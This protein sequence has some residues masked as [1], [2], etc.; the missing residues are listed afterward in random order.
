VRYD[1]PAVGIEWPLP[2]SVI[3]PKDLE[4]PPIQRP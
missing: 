2:V 4:W 3:H 1:D